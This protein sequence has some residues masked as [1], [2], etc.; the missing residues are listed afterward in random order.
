MTTKLSRET[1]SRSEFG[2]EWL[3]S[4]EAEELY[5]LLLSKR[6][7]TLPAGDS[8]AT[9]ELVEAGFAIRPY[10]SDERLLPIPPE[11]AVGRAL[12]RQ[13]Q[14]WLRAAPDLDRAVKTFQQLHQLNAAPSNK[15]QLLDTADGRQ[16]S[17]TSLISAARHDVCLMQPY[18]YWMA[19]LSRDDP[20]HSSSPDSGSVDQGVRHRFL[21]DE[22]ILSDAGFRATALKEIDSGIE[23]RVAHHLPTWML[24]A[25]SASA[26]YLPE[27]S[28]GV[29]AGTQDSGLV[30]LLQ[31][32]FDAVWSSARPLHGSARAELLSGPEREVLMLVASGRTN[33]AIA[34]LLGV[35]DRT[36]RRHVR[37]LTDFYGSN[38]RTTLIAAIISSGT[39]DAAHTPTTNG[40]SDAARIRPA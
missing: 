25:D 26:L 36:V 24:I 17:A 27:P 12:T 20:D 22:R 10:G 39:T 19:D 3:L 35:T 9:A 29:G 33:G 23:A 28:T 31:L 32:A 13:T 40:L 34:R 18:P 4:I 30:A 8:S 1:R 2:L 21:Y 7:D 14:K 37:A 5:E 38:D 16:Q 6:C 15:A 11:V